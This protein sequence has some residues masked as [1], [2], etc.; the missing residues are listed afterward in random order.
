MDQTNAG[1]DG[2]RGTTAWNGHPRKL[3]IFESFHASG[4]SGRLSMR[5][6]TTVF[7]CIHSSF[8]L[9][10][11]GPIACTRA[12]TQLTKV[13]DADGRREHLQ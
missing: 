13:T 9:P 2:S 8:S 4:A 5:R 6:A 11:R 12:I 7:K 10:M 1:S 3:A